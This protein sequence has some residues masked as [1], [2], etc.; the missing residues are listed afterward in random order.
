MKLVIIMALGLMVN[1]PVFCENIGFVDLQKVFVNYK[2]TEKAKEGFEKKQ[3]ELREELEKKQKKLEKA[4]KDNKKP[5]EIQ[6]MVAEIQEE[7]QPKQE[8]LM[9]LNNQIMTAI[10]SDI[11]ISTKK[12]AKEY[13]IEIVLDKQAVLNGGFDLTDFVI[14]DLNN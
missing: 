3:N 7:L 2:E 5:E 4:Q 8:E 9:N 6:K 10:R 12:V 1:L 13:G 11:I 14:D